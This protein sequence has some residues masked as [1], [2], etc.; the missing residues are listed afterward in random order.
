MPLGS[1]A[2]ARVPVLSARPAPLLGHTDPGRR[3]DSKPWSPLG[4]LFPIACHLIPF[5]KEAASQC[6][7]ARLKSHP[8]GRLRQE[9]HSG[10]LA[11]AAQRLSEALSANL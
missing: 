8:W 7:G 3:S 11:W 1:P 2:R 4:S 5:F 10:I 9:G 6:P